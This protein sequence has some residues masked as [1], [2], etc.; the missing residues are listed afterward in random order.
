MLE[1]VLERRRRCSPGARGRSAPP[2]PRLVNEVIEQ[3]YRSRKSAGGRPVGTMPP[4]PQGTEGLLGS[5]G[6]GS[7][8][9]LPGWGNQ[10]DS[11][12]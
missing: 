1:S 4:G 5:A 3:Q 12:R 11:C 7:P 10:P 8:D 9:V 2:R 6:N